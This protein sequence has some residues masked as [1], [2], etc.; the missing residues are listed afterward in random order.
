MLAGRNGEAGMLEMPIVDQRLPVSGSEGLLDG[1][2]EFRGPVI[3]FAAP[4]DHAEV[5]DDIAAAEYEDAF[6]TERPQ[7]SADI[8]V[9]LFGETGVDAHLQHGDIGFRIEMREDRPGTVVE[10]PGII[11]LNR[12]G[13]DAFRNPSRQ[14]RSARS[15]VAKCGVGFWKAVEIMDSGRLRHAG[16]EC[17]PGGD[18]VGRN[19]EDSLGSRERRRLMSPFLA[20]FVVFE[21][22][23]WRTVADEES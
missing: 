1:G 17:R 2:I 8:P 14:L 18:P 16:Y 13:S 10:T 11:E 7:L 12:N 3:R 22:I 15:R 19:G 20:P 6:I 9:L 21:G 23:I 4:A 5:M